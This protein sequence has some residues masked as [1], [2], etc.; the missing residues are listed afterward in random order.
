MSAKIPT[1]ATPAE[2]IIMRSK[3]KQGLKHQQLDNYNDSE[4]EAGDAKMYA[5]RANGMSKQIANNN[6]IPKFENSVFDMKY[7]SQVKQEEKVCSPKSKAAKEKKK[8]DQ[9]VKDEKELIKE[10]RAADQLSQ[11][12]PEFPLAHPNQL[13]LRY[14]HPQRMTEKFTEGKQ[15]TITFDSDF[16]SGNLSRVTRGNQRNEFNLWVS[17][18]GAPYTEDGYRTWFH[19]SVHGVP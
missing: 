12:P 1:E 19:F 10:R 9:D 5:A 11:Y 13:N 8:V 17:H 14:E 18:D 3:Q 4:G 16:C 7:K 6:P 2:K 15:T